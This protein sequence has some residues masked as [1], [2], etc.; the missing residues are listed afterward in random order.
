M[1]QSP[2]VQNCVHVAQ[3]PPLPPLP[4]SSAS[5]LVL[6]QN[7]EIQLPAQDTMGAGSPG[8][9]R[10]RK[11]SP[12]RASGEHGPKTPFAQTPGLLCCERTKVCCF[13]MSS[14]WSL[15]TAAPGALMHTV[16]P[17]GGWWVSRITLQVP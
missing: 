3:T 5:A 15:V 6:A 16:L 7:E 12:L 14:S 4:W 9:W 10:S 1:P 17:F 11:A 13:K 2:D 8:G